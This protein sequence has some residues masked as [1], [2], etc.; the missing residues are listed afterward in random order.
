MNLTNVAT[1]RMH[2]SV[3][4]RIA[5]SRRA[6]TPSLLGSTKGQTTMK[7]KTAKPAAA[8]AKKAAPAK[9]APAKA[10]APAKK[11]AAKVAKKK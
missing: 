2:N 3:C 6:V 8:A 10:A 1:T 7:A 9:A 11:A 5:R 4:G